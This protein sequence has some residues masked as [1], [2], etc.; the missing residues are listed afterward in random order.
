MRTRRLLAAC[1]SL[2]FRPCCYSRREK[3][4]TGS[5]VSIPRPNSRLPLPS[6]ESPESTVYP[7][8]MAAQPLREEP[9]EQ[10][11]RVKICGL[12]RVDEAVACLQAG[13]DYIGLNFHPGSRRFVDLS[14]AK[15]IIQAIYRPAQAVGLFVN[16]P[17][18]E[19]A[20]VADQLG[21]ECIQ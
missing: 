3:K 10:R 14:Q 5:S 21:L 20:S 16:R 12:T 13:A 1:E 18:S 9:H 17:A 15:Q 4:S 7:V 8:R 2:P 6:S 19:V 11:V